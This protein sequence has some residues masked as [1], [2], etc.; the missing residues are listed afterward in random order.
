MQK[1]DKYYTFLFTRYFKINSPL[2]VSKK[3]LHNSAVA[4]FLLAIISTGIFGFAKFDVSNTV[5]AQ[6]KSQ[7][8]SQEITPAQPRSNTEVKSFNYSRPASANI[9]NSKVGGPDEPYQMVE[10]MDN[11]ENS[12][13]DQLLSIEKS[14]SPDFIPTMWAHF[15]KVNNEYGYRRNPFG[16]GGYEFHSGMDIDGEKGEAVLA[17]AK[18]TIVKAGWH[19]GYGNL[20]EV[21]HGNGLR[22]RYGHLSRIGVAIGE[23]IER[24][25]LIGLVGSTGRS[26]GPH[27]HYEVRINDRAINPRRFLPPGMPN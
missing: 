26:T 21:D 4:A 10:E 6:N 13:E 16:G 14:S 22:T 3:V 18:G 25:Q 7:T 17:P 12:V 2:K 1:D 15:G 5:F 11:S 23:T 8:V 20:I 19:G 24:G 9:Q 27:L